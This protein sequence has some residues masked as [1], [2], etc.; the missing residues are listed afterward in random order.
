[1][2]TSPENEEAWTSFAIEPPKENRLE[3]DLEH[4]RTVHCRPWDEYMAPTF[5]TLISKVILRVEIPSTVSL[6]TSIFDVAST[7]STWEQR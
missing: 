1:M 2:F 5:A 7:A 3:L 4:D 6:I